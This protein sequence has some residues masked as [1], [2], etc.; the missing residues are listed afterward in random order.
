LLAPAWGET[1]GS[2]TQTHPFWKYATPMPQGRFRSFTLSID[3][4][5]PYFAAILTAREKIFDSQHPIPMANF[6]HKA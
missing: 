2:G 3:E 6:L 4:Q 5:K 1:A